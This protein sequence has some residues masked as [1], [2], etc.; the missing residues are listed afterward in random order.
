MPNTNGL[1]NPHTGKHA[2]HNRYDPMNPNV[3]IAGNT[4][5]QYASQKSQ[6]D[7]DVMYV[8]SPVFVGNLY[9]R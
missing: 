3:T 1:M 8:L 7:A 4:F 5:G 6:D 2:L 9:G